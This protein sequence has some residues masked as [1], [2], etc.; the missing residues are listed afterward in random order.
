MKRITLWSLLTVV[1]CIFT[2]PIQGIASDGTQPFVVVSD[3]YGSSNYSLSNGDG[4]LTDQQE[5]IRFDPSDDWSF[6]NGVGDFDND[7]AQDFILAVGYEAGI[8][9]LFGKIEDSGFVEQSRSTEWSRGRYPGRMAVADF[10]E[11]GNL[12]FVMTY[13][14]SIDCDLYKGHGDLTFTPVEI[15]N[16]APSASIGADS[17]DFNGDGHADFVVVSYST[18]IAYINL[19]NG[20]GDFTT[21]QKTLIYWSGYRSVAAADLNGDG[22]DDLVVSFET[23]YVQYMA[24]FL[25]NGYVEIDSN[26]Y[27]YGFVHETYIINPNIYSSPIDLYDLDND[28][29]H[30]LIIGGYNHQTPDG[31]FHGIGVMLGTGGGYFGPAKSWGG[32]TEDLDLI[33]SVSAPTLLPAEVKKNI[34]PVAILYSDQYEVVSGQ[35]VFLDGQDSYDEDGEIVSYE[36][37]FGDDSA[38]LEKDPAD[39]SIAEVATAEYV[40][41][42]P[43]TYTVILTV[44]DDQGATGV[45]EVTITVTAHDASMRILPG[46]LNLKSRGRWVHAWVKLPEGFDAT[47]VNV[48]SMSIKTENGSASLGSNDITVI[49]RKWMARHGRFY[50]RMNRQTVINAVETAGGP[51]NQTEFE[52]IGSAD[53]DGHLAAFEAEDT[54]R[55]IKKNKKKRKS[56]RGCKRRWRRGR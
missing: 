29:N 13:D 22:L 28:G 53:Y 40:Y 27:G 25:N 35:P 43:G 3:L 56:W 54:I 47:T 33:T 49:T 20:E 2:V 41:Y 42:D 17:G 46:T 8:V 48:D 37:D 1:C 45:A 21:L 6:S 19:G 16:A 44:V 9:Y 39:K 15:G 32:D 23:P 38:V 12:D 51:S 55:T 7:G 50:L 52:L 5:I 14:G 18:G 26:A 4:T 36:W 11:D 31:Y 30:D 10:D 34:E 24:V